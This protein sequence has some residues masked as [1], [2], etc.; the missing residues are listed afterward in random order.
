MN[1]P[2]AASARP[3]PNQQAFATSN[4]GSSGG[5]EVAS[6]DTVGLGVPTSYGCHKV[7]NYTTRKSSSFFLCRLIVHNGVT[8]QDLR[9]EWIAPRVLKL[10]LA[11]P[12]WFQMAEQ[13][14]QFTVDDEGNMIFPPEHPLTMDTNE[15]NQRLVE[16]DGRIW[17]NGVLMFEQDML[18][19]AFDSELVDVAI[20][21]TT[22][23]VLQLYL[24][25]V[26][27]LCFLFLLRCLIAVSNNLLSSSLVKHRVAPDETVNSTSKSV[28]Y[29]GRKVALGAGARPTPANARNASN[30]F[31]QGGSKK[32]KTGG[33]EESKDD[34]QT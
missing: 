6:E 21:S 3:R 2:P 18:Q 20:G 32:K 12:D 26:G 16:E 25:Y 5:G 27:A 4:E 1:S 13:M 19:E 8:M 24:E 29:A 31:A 33:V 34:M 11:W 14:A 22:V 17:D 10:C 30:V 28:K 7:F 15:R 23:K 9:L